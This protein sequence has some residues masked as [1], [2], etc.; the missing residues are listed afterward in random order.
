MQTF[1]VKSFL[2][3]AKVNSFSFLNLSIYDLSIISC[4][5]A[6]RC[7]ASIKSLQGSFVVYC[8]IG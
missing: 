6:R 7:T 4:L 3:D 8:M 5:V 2:R 1:K